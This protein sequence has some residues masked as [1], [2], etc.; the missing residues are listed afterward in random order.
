MF[1]PVSKVNPEHKAKYIY[2]L[3][4]AASVTET[5]KKVLKMLVHTHLFDN[6]ACLNWKGNVC[7]TFP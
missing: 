7:L 2:V 4:Y 6:F 1:K 5:Y 3:S